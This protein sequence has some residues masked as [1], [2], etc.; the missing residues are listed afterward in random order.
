MKTATKLQ[1]KTEKKT[2]INWEKWLNT[3]QNIDCVKGMEMIPDGS[4]DLIITD[5]PYGISKELNCKG[6]RLG[7]TAKL[8]F[9][10][11]EWD[12][13]NLEWFEIAVKKTRGWM[14][15]FCAKKDV[16]YFIE[17]LER[18]GF[19]AVDVIV[20]QKPDPVPLNAKS[21]FLNAWEAI[22]VGKRPGTHWGSNYEHNIIKVQA[23]K[24]KNRIHP[25]QKPVAL[26]KKLI[27]LTTKEG[28][29]VLDPFMGSG[30]TAV[31]SIESKRKYIGFEISKEY[32][33]QAKNRIDNM[34]KVLF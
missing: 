32:F 22:V 20:W 13:F 9:N 8:N 5:P 23:P 29:L 4:V 25:T 31:A 16:G 27:E 10:F 28:D 7:T 2:D 12:K 34:P 21:R 6:Q 1:K 3:I 14:M 18:D 19:V 15:T 11:G 33:K 17:R 24:G 26:I 30:T